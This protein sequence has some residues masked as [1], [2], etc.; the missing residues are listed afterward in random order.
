[1]IMK[2]MMGLRVYESL[3]LKHQEIV[4]E[5]TDSGLEVEGEQLSQQELNGKLY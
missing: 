1:M 3:K 5:V 4:D 2:L